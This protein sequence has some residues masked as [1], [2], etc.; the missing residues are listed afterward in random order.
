M[1]GWLLIYTFQADQIAT[2][3]ANIDYAIVQNQVLALDRIKLTL[4]Q[5]LFIEVETIDLNRVTKRWIIKIQDSVG[6]GDFFGIGDQLCVE[7]RLYLWPKG[8]EYLVQID[9]IDLVLEHVTP[10]GPVADILPEDML[11]QT[12][13]VAFRNPQ[14][15]NRLD[16]TLIDP[17]GR[18]LGFAGYADFY[19]G[20]VGEINNMRAH[21]M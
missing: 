13:V 7:L 11:D 4:D 17:P 1:R 16:C 15:G 6:T 9:H 8:F 2:V 20:S 12:R 3:L 14:D 10:V 19:A 21:T 18:Q 5:G